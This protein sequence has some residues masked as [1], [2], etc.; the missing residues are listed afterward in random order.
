MKRAGGRARRNKQPQCNRG[1]ASIRQLLVCE[2]QVQM[3][4]LIYED[5]FTRSVMIPFQKKHSVPSW[6]S[7]FT[8]LARK[9]AYSLKTKQ[10][11]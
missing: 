9:I 5:V 10:K 1:L 11:D 8:L 2:A 4:I 6:W 3:S 7:A